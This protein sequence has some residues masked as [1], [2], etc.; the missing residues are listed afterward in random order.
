MVKTPLDS[1]SNNTARNHLIERKGK[2]SWK[3]VSDE[4]K[5]NQGYLNRVARGM[6]P[7]S[8]RLRIALGLRPIT[9]AVPPCASCGGVHVTKRCAKNAHHKY[10]PHPV[11][12]WKTLEKVLTPGEYEDLLERVKGAKTK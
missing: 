3:A 11:V 4:L 6:R 7:A 2:L 9:V 5:F 10:A 12:R 1:E 8:N